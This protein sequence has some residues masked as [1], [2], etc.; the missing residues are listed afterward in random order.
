ML[1]RCGAIVALA[2]LGACSPAPA[3]PNVIVYVVD[4]LRADHLGLYGYERDTSPRLDAFARDAVVFEAAYSPSSWTRPS[5]AS[6][7]TGRYPLAHGAI[8]RADA[9]APG[10]PMLSE[11]LQAA[12]Y[13]TAA[14]STN[15]NVLPIW[16]FGR[17]F[18]DFYDIDPE[19]WRARSEQVNEVVIRYLDEHSDEPFF[20]Y[21]HTRDPHVPY[22]PPP[23]FDAFWPA[24]EDDNVV[25]R[26]DGEIRA[27]DH[28]F[29]ELLDHL[30]ERGL[31]RDSLILFTSDHGEEM[32]DR[33][34]VGHG[35]SLFEEVVVIPF[36]LKY[37]GNGDGGTRQLGPAAL[38]DVLPTVLGVVD[39]EF[40]E[41]LAGV[42]LRARPAD[43]AR[44][45]FFD[46][47]L[48][49]SG[50]RYVMDGVRLGRHKLVEQLEPRRQRLLFDVA[51]DPGERRAITD[52][53]P[54]LGQHLGRLLREFRAVARSG[55]QLI[56]VGSSESAWIEADVRL[57]T[58]GRFVRLRG[59]E[60]ESDD[61]VELAEDGRSLTLELRLPSRPNPTG[62][63]PR[64]LVDTDRIAVEVDPVGAEVVVEAARF[65]TEPAPVFLGPE[66]TPA[67]EAPVSFRRD[68]PELV[69]ERMDTLLPIVNQRSVLARPG[70]YVGTVA[71]VGSEV[72]IDAETE[73]RLRE[74]GY[75]E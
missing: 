73:R 15:V 4:A 24:G 19:L 36:V 41:A 62:G 52:E 21:I 35:D 18:D 12:G 7:L 66:L 31:Y 63:R 13:R 29:G 57:S 50:K 43:T 30:R 56:L 45:L 32:F 20:L 22:S 23:P 53:E 10:I 5:T 27:N 69:V 6:L 14:F 70:L 38:I 33:G 51:A 39:V 26:Y 47:N 16:G 44:P 72:E 65:G 2:L 42:D 64:M 28:F 25:N 55:L 1:R 74:L 60:L 67:G 75:A 71:P 11:I 49:R 37:P 34:E 3:P 54:A 61:V 46:L 48:L 9:I 68:A 8:K 58:N 17:G 59:I 40:P